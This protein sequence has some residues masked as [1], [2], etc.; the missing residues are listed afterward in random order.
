MLRVLTNLVANAIK[1][2]P[3]G[4]DIV[5]RVAPAADG[6]H[7]SVSDQGLGVPEE[8]RES[9]FS[10]YGRIARPEQAAIEGTGLGLP[11]ARHIVE[12]HHGRIWVESNSPT[13]SIFFV[14]LPLSQPEA[15]L[16]REPI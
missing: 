3:M 8:H 14:Y 12:M 13:G 4:G 16:V 11:I 15:M 2:A 7:L 1:Y 6:V 5:L 9:I 10:R